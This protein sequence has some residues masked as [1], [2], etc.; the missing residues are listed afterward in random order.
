MK[1]MF[2]LVDTCGK[3]LADCLHKA[4]ADGK[5]IWCC[6]FNHFSERGIRF[7]EFIEYKVYLRQSSLKTASIWMSVY[8]KK[9]LFSDTTVRTVC[10]TSE[11]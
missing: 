7:K 10:S 9:Y 1:M 4:T 8:K 5:F 6:A 2:C 11:Q 3:E